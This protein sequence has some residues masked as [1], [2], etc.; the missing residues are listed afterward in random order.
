MADTGTMVI[1]IYEQPTVMEQNFHFEFDYFTTDPS[2][3]YDAMV[4]RSTSGGTLTLTGAT[5]AFSLVGVTGGST[6][7][8]ESFSTGGATFGA[9]NKLKFTMTFVSNA[10]GTATYTLA[11]TF[12]NTPYTKTIIASSDSITTLFA[13]PMTF[14]I[15][16]FSGTQ[17]KNIIFNEVSCANLGGQAIQELYFDSDDT[18]ALI[19]DHSGNDNNVAN[20]NNSTIVLKNK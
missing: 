2:T 12:N 7:I 1:C 9:F 4:L 3:T 11:F 8:N 6:I 16:G 20:T 17:I 19:H 5:T 10:S 15:N 14:E 18:T 13:S